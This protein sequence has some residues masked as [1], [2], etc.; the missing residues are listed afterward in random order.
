M[1]PGRRGGNHPVIEGNT[2]TPSGPMAFLGPHGARPTHCSQAGGG[3]PLGPGALLWP[4]RQADPG[5][6][7]SEGLGR[8][9]AISRG[10]VLRP[11][12]DVEGLA[13]RPHL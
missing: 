7:G 11:D 12:P 1:T 4:P 5:P 8:G 13:R 10:S 6:G 9:A 3:R 2:E